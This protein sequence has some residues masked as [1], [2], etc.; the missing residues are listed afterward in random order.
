MIVLYSTRLLRLLTPW[1]SGISGITIFPFIILRSELRGTVESAVT[2]NHEKI[3]IRQ[4]LELLLVFFALW[5]TVSF[6]AG[7][8]RGRGWYGAYR[9]IIF[10]REAFDR[11]YDPDYLSRRKLFGFM[12]FRK[13]QVC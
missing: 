4:Q 11:M 5:Y 10:E 3:H 8:A 12:K 2:V 9:N 6:I 13:K 7:L 1:F